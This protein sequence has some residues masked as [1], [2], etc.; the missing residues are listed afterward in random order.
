[1]YGKRA[2][3]VL[4]ADLVAVEAKITRLRSEQHVLVR[5][6]EYGQAP[7]S[8]GSRS[9]VDY[10]Q[11]RL[12]IKRDTARD[13]VFAARRFV[14]HR[15]LHDRMLNRDATFDR[16]IAA[17][18]LADAG[19]AP[20]V[21]D[22][23]YRRDL[24]GVATLMVNTRRVTPVDERQ[25]FN[26]RYFTIQ[27]NLDESSYRMWG[28]APGGIGRT[29]ERAVCDRADQLRTTAR[30]LPSTRGQRQLDA[31]ATMALDSLKGSATDGGSTSQVTVFIDARQDNPTETTT[32]IEYGPRV[33][34]DTLDEIQCGGRAQ[35][36]GLDTQG[37]PVVTTPATRTIPPAIR[38]QVAHRDGACV[39]DGCA[40]LY[41]LQPHHIRRFT[42]QSRYGVAQQLQRNAG[43]VPHPDDHVP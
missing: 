40:S 20:D 10:V 13:L 15:G 22:E 41:R 35:I 6:L 9:M 7:Q 42:D 36:V 37:I 4:E 26:G 27:P 3:G 24:S 28:E 23:S 19:A 43:G 16:T 34:P 21:V 30:E 1:M 31:L 32:V 25:V 33:G 14:K 18:K 39:I 11:S 5:E 8:D 17:V 12:D 38:H 2:I 29:I